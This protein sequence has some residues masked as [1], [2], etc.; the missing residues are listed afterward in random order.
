MALPAT[1]Q[2]SISLW[3][4]WRIIS[5]SLHVPGSPSSAFTTKYLGLGHE[6]EGNISFINGVHIDVGL[7]SSWLNQYWFSPFLLP[8]AITGFVHETPL[9]SSGEAC[10]PSAPEPR[11]LNLIQ[12]PFWSLQHDLLSLVPVASFYCSLQSGRRRQTEMMRFVQVIRDQAE[13][14]CIKCLFFLPPVMPAV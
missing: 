2:P 3:G 8:P 4:S 6:D 13:W 11:D 14:F 10:S 9:H 5:R 12:Y 7:K 1:R